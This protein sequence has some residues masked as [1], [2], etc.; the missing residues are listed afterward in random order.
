MGAF[1]PFVMDPYI[2]ALENNEFLS[3]PSVPVSEA[4]KLF[5]RPTSFRLY[6]HPQ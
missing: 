3:L 4:S 2:P 5:L 1:W 6:F